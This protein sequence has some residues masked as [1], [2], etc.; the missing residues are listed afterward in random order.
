MTSS[1]V[2]VLSA[3]N[4]TCQKSLFHHTSSPPPQPT[5]PWLLPPTQTSTNTLQKRNNKKPKQPAH[6]VHGERRGEVSS[7]H[8]RAFRRCLFLTASDRSFGLRQSESLSRSRLCVVTF[9]EATSDICGR[10]RLA[11]GHNNGFPKGLD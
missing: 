11:G 8:P 2:I 4:P 5:L 1:A 7:S 3:Y 6:G 10:H 9:G